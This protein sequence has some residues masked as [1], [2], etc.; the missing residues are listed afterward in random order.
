MKYHL[1]L[2]DISPPPPPCPS[3]SSSYLPIRPDRLI[4]FHVT[5][6]WVLSLCVPAKAEF[7]LVEDGDELDDPEA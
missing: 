3:S 5:L 7:Y 1:S 2:N 6:S 4:P